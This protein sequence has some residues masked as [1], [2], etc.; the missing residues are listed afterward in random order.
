[1]ADIFELFKKISSGDSAPSKLTHIVAGLGNPGEKYAFTR[2]NA[3]FLAL[4]YAAE[5]LG[6]DVKKL[7]FKSLTDQT[8]IGGHGVLLLKPQTYMN[9]SGDAVREAMDFYKL[10]PE[11]LIVLVDDIYQAPGK[12]RVRKSGSAGGHNGLKDIIAKISSD[13]FPRIRIGVGEKPSPDYDLAS[14]VTGKIPEEDRKK[15]F[16]VFGCAYD[17]LSMLIDGKV[18]EAMGKYNGISF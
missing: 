8:T 5:K 2:H 3:G 15:L 7:R 12:M 9:L 6:A 13:T 18:D 17:A 14:W 11:R 4:D 10:P 1:M 16:S